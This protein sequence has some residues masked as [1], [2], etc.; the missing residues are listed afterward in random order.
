MAWWLRALGALAEELSS[1]CRPTWQLTD[2][3]N[4]SFRGS[5]N[6]F[7]PPWVPGV[8]MVHRQNTPTHKIF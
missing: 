8:R 6:H 1:I 4:S 2:I 7:L 3:C 5:N